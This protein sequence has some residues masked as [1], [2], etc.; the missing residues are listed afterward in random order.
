MHILKGG[1]SDYG[2]V[3]GEA[4][5]EDGFS[6]KI[7]TIKKEK[8]IDNYPLVDRNP[9]KDIDEF[10]K[11]LGVKRRIRSDAV[12][13]VSIIVD[14]PKD[15]TRDE[16]EFFQE[17][18]K[19]LQEHFG[20][21]DDAILYAQVHLDEGHPHMHFS[22]VPLV[23][24]E[25]KYKDGHSEKQ[26][27]LSAFDV[28]TKKSLCNLHPFMQTHMWSK[29]FT[30]TLHHNDGVKRDKDFLEHKLK[31]LEEELAEKRQDVHMAD[32]ELQSIKNET[33]LLKSEYERNKKL[34]EDMKNTL[35]ID[36]L[37]EDVELLDKQIEEK[38][39]ILKSLESSIK[40][41]IG[42]IITG[43][44]NAVKISVSISATDPER[45]EQYLV[46][47]QKKA[48]AEAVELPPPVDQEVK[49]AVE[50]SAEKA[51]TFIRR[52]RGR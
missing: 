21:K 46:Q 27:K 23:E 4:L 11:N 2:S 43:F 32:L 45:A 28:L 52:R 3:K 35:N 18:I 39:N 29:G 17:S 50:H 30:G 10:I 37:F 49:A 7:G 24:K 48:K 42:H 12:R 44:M 36:K 20:I 26:I 25:K 31:Q 16:R 5:R 14:Y 51:A 41:R 33:M 19:G 6:S 13:F 8:T 34:Y 38:K 15:E 22:F 47:G 1:A 9:P 40:D